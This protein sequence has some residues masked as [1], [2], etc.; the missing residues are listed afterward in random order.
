MKTEQEGFWCRC[1]HFPLSKYTSTWLL[2][3]HG[4]CQTKMLSKWL[5]NILEPSC[6]SVW[7]SSLYNTCLYFKTGMCQQKVHQVIFYCKSCHLHVTNFLLLPTKNSFP[8]WMK[9][10]DTSIFLSDRLIHNIHIYCTARV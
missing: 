2:K 9:W 8:E 1:R 3:C 4:G 7:C 10:T 5:Q 6:L